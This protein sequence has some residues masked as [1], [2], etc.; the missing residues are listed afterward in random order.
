M[1]LEEGQVLQTAQPAIRLPQRLLLVSLALLLLLVVAPRSYAAGPVVV[2]LFTTEGCSSCPPAD[3][4]LAQV[5]GK[6]LN[7]VELIGLGEHV[8]YWNSSAWKD[9]FSSSQFTDRQNDYIAWMHL[10]SPYTPQ[11]VIDGRVQVLGN[12]GP[13][14][15]RDLAAATAV[16]KPATVTLSWEGPSKLHI[17]AQSPASSGLKVM[18]AITED[19]LTT[20]IG[21]GENKGRT[22]QHA[23]V[24]RELKA[25]GKPS[26][27]N[28]DGAVDVPAHSDWNTGKLRA[29]VFVQDF[30]SGEIL[31]AAAIPYQHA[32]TS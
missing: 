14:I 20:S 11:M 29:V 26:H 7:G 1:K 22:L 32:P 23:A 31:G 17:V 24:V 21:G 19:G 16:P 28:F 18:L 9:R 13:A 30:H 10:K 5:N 2:E 15:G 8:D 27:G 3:A 12:D 6:T 4:L 25:V